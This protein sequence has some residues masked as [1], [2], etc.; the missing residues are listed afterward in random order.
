MC[1]ARVDQLSR[2]DMCC[3]LVVETGRVDSPAGVEEDVD[4]RRG[5][6]G[7]R[8]R[9]QRHDTEVILG[10]HHWVN[11]GLDGCKQ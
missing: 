2:G 6:G 7:Q 9:V 1:H 5:N 3:S 4:E 8:V 11:C 10:D